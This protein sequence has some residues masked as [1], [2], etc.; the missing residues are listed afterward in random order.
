MTSEFRSLVCVDENRECTESP[1]FKYYFCDDRGRLIDRTSLEVVEGQFI[2]TAAS[3]GCFRFLV[4]S[5]GLL[6][7]VAEQAERGHEVIS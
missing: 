1:N 4:L 2:R 6:S 3:I 7:L 5:F